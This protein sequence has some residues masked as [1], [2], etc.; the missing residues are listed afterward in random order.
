MRTVAT[1]LLVLYTSTAI[2]E[3]PC[4]DPDD[5]EVT[6]R[7]A[8]VQQHLDDDQ[9]WSQVWWYGWMAAYTALA[10]GQL[11]LGLVQDENKT[12]DRYLVGMT[13]SVLGATLLAARPMTS[14]YGADWLRATA[15]GTAEE[16]LEKLRVAEDLL[17]TAHDRQEAARGWLAHTA[18]AVWSLGSSAFV[19]W[20]IKDET[21]ALI[22]L[23]GSTVLGEGRVLTAPS[24]SIDSFREY[25]KANPTPVCTVEA[26]R[27]PQAPPSPTWAIVPSG[28]GLGAV[29][30]F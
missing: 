12:R 2:A 17:E 23:I 13:G 21:G 25:R 11:T 14:A 22:N 28:L 4:A 19:Y 1:L 5:A 15:D 6:T 26:R 9:L 27:R 18:G 10:V 20:V 7:I 30:R 24:G 8:A 3:V 16:R 29:V